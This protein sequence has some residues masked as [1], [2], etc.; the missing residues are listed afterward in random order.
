MVSAAISRED[1]TALMRA[2]YLQGL[3]H[4][5]HN[6]IYRKRS[7]FFRSR[8]WFITSYE[9]DC[10]YLIY[11]NL[12]YCM[13]GRKQ[14]PPALALAWNWLHFFEFGKCWASLPRINGFNTECVDRSD[15]NGSAWIHHSLR[16]VNGVEVGIT[17]NTSH[18]WMHESHWRW[19]QRTFYP[20][21]DSCIQLAAQYP[22]CT[23]LQWVLEPGIYKQE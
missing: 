6:K 19:A 10:R 8:G 18:N 16:N 22:Y 5:V 23:Y 4:F 1:S 14:G 9:L 11:K 3:H 2:P 12:E 20:Q 17:H 21:G 15:H 7:N 13:Y